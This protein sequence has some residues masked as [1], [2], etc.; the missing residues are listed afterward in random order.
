[1]LVTIY[2]LLK[3]AKYLN[4]IKNNE[5]EPSPLILCLFELVND[6]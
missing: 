1:M 2:D 6:C 3:L 4:K 5:N